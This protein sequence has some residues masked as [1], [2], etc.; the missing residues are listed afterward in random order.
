MGDEARRAIV[1]A[2]FAK[3]TA[4]DIDGIIAMFEPDGFV[5]SPFLGRMPAPDFYA[6]LGAASSAA[7]LTVHGIMGDPEAGKY[8]AHFRYD[9]T[10]ASGED[11]MFEGIDLFTFGAGERFRSME[12]FYDTHPLRAEV[13]D[14]YERA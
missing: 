13:G 6:K 14:K 5:V 2:Y 7:T 8:A 9:W 1:R 10:L 4:I 12:I 11:L 3:M